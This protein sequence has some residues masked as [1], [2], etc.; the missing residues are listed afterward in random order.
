[1]KML[2]NNT[3]L[4]FK[5]KLFVELYVFLL[6]ISSKYFFIILYYIKAL[7]IF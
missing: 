3:F 6:Y 4:S 2:K 5:I 7:N 1:M